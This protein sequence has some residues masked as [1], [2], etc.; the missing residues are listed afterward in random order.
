MSNKTP[1]VKHLTV[2]RKEHGFSQEVSLVQRNREE[3]IQNASAQ[4]ILEQLGPMSQDERDYYD[5]L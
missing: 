2:F 3:N 5:N 1:I 4:D